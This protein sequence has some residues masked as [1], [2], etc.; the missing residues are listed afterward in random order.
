M[1]RLMFHAE[2]CHKGA[3]RNTSVSICKLP[4]KKVDDVGSARVGY[5]IVPILILIFLEIHLMVY[6]SIR[7]WLIY[8][9]PI[10]RHISEALLCCCFVSLYSYS[11]SYPMNDRE[12]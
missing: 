5:Y 7:G 12:K 10:Y 3:V 9:C 11:Y 8:F 4:S 2:K 6:A 1:R